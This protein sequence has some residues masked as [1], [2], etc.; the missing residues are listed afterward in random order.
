MPLSAMKKLG[1]WLVKALLWI[2]EVVANVVFR[3]L[4]ENEK[5][6]LPPIHDDVLLESAADLARKIREGHITSVRVVG[7]YIRRIKEIN[8]IVNC[9]VDTR[10]W[11]FAR[12]VP[13]P[14]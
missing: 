14:S 6:F 13:L 10:L 3:L 4:F 12:T 5:K 2:I 7:A 9:F 8:P 11:I 1:L